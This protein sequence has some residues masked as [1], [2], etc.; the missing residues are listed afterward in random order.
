MKEEGIEETWCAYLDPNVLSFKVSPTSTDTD[1]VGYQ[2]NLVSRKFG[3]SQL[4][5]KSLFE[6]P[7]NMCL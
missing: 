4:R 2:P 3:L 6:R 7:E 5:P 1:L